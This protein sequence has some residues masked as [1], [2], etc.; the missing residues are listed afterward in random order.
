MVYISP[1]SLVAEVQQVNYRN[2]KVVFSAN[3]CL[4]IGNHTP[5]EGSN[6]SEESYEILINTINKISKLIL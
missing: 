2:L 5:T 3:P 1:D 6:N 4:L